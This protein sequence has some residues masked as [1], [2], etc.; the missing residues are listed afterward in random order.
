VGA[1]LVDFAEVEF[2]DEGFFLCDAGFGED[3]T[4][5]AG[6]EALTP[7]FD[8]VADDFFVAD[9]IGNSD[10]AAVGNGVAALDGFPGGMLSLAM[11]FFFRRMPADGG[12]IEENLGPLHRGETG[13][14]GIPLIPANQN[15]DFAIAGLPGA[16]AE[17]ARCEIEFFV[18]QR[19]VGNVHL[20]VQAEERAVGIDDRGGVVINARGAFFEQRSDDYY[21]I[22]FR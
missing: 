20:P 12:G 14:F 11:F 8:A 9:A 4:G 18:E 5:G 2:D 10:V 1:G 21:S 16:E 19:I 15:A 13:S 3:F 17:V 22:V 7:E 6:D